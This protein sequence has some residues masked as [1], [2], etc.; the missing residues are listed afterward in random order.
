LLR[1]GRVGVG[2]RNEPTRTWRVRTGEDIGR[3]IADLRRMRGLTQAELAKETGTTRSYLAL[4]ESGR[5][6]R[7][8]EHLL[9]VLRRMGAT[10]T[11][12]IPIEPGEP[13]DGDG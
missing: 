13:A 3:A 1:I 5:S 10:V 2:Q 12:S 9:R 7:L 8:L 11:I 6:V 4:M